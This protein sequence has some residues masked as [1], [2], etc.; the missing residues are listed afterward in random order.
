[1]KR[2]ISPLLS[3]ILVLL[4]A[5]AIYVL[6]FP[7]FK[8]ITMNLGEDTEGASQRP[9]HCDN[10]LLSVD[11]VYRQPDSIVATIG[12]KNSGTFKIE[13]F[14][15]TRQTSY[16]PESSCMMLNADLNPNI[17]KNFDIPIFTPFNLPSSLCPIPTVPAGSIPCIYI[18]KINLVPWIN[19]DGVD[20]S[21]VDKLL[22]IDV[23]KLNKACDP[24]PGQV[25][26]PGTSRPCGINIGECREGVEECVNGQ[27]SGNC[28]GEVTPV[29]ERCDDKDNDCDTFTDEDFKPPLGNLGQPCSLGV[30]SCQQSG[31]F[32]C[33][34]D[35][36]GTE[37]N[38][39]PLPPGIELC[40]PNE[41]G[42]GVDE[43]CDG[44]VDDGCLV[45]VSQNYE[46]EDAMRSY[47][48]PPGTVVQRCDCGTNLPYHGIYPRCG[49]FLPPNDI[50]SCDINI[51][52]FGDCKPAGGGDP[53]QCTFLKNFDIYA[54]RFF[55]F[56]QTISIPDPSIDLSLV[57]CNVGLR[58]GIGDG[59]DREDLFV[60]INNEKR[61]YLDDVPGAIIQWVP[62]EITGFRV[63]RLI[64]G[65][66][67]IRFGMPKDPP[68]NDVSSSHVD[69]Y[70]FTCYNPIVP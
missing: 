11:N 61:I 21:C 39:V 10:I 68:E 2:G 27:W 23:A 17:I 32:V 50:L 59:Q 46:I 69:W 35:G 14:T 44:F 13:R 67:I 5:V 7:W 19:I 16:Q 47:P 58:L 51:R 40:F 57:T 28:I 62:K 25:C 31:Q 52:D 33:R 53:G 41:Y 49:W 3:F 34:A 36:S 24:G 26:V 56:R 37:C 29:N 8:S 1:M 22:E 70:N 63:G 18:N 60:E 6:L 9:L 65:D 30:G 38:A 48:D 55:G 43:D 54:D 15:V 66:N 12:V 20:I 4:L 42:N 45:W 64:E